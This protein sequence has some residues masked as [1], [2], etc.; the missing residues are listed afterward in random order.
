MLNSRMSAS[1][2]FDCFKECKK[3]EQTTPNEKTHGVTTHISSVIKIYVEKEIEK[4][5][6]IKQLSKTG[7]I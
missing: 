5:I 2:K 6:T 7:M 3:K 4:I 1:S